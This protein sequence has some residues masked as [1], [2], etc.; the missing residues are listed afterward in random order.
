MD[1]IVT[2]ETSQSVTDLHVGTLQVTDMCSTNFTPVLNSPLRRNVSLCGYEKTRN[3]QTKKK[4]NKQINILNK[5]TIICTDLLKFLWHIFVCCYALQ[6]ETKKQFIFLS[7]FQF[8]LEN[9]KIVRRGTTMW[10]SIENVPFSF[11][12]FHRTFIFHAD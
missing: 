2:I 1:F 10:I 3:E 5:K 9:L 4:K 12:Y 7:K 11:T 6:N 8:D